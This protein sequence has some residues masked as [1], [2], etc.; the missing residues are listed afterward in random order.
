MTRKT[1]NKVIKVAIAGVGNCASSLVQ[2]LHYYS[3]YSKSDGLMH[4]NIGGYLPT[5]IEITAAFDIDERKVGKTLSEA[6]F[7][8]P[9]CTTT[10]YN[11]NKFAFNG[12]NVEVLMAPVM[13]GYSEHM[14]RFPPEK[15]FIVANKKSVDVKKVLIESG[16]DI[17]VN[18][19]PV[20]SEN[21]AR[22][23][24]QAC[25]EADVSFI[26]C[27][28]AFIV[29]DKEW[30]ERFKVSGIPA[31]GD[32]IKSQVG[33]T[34]LHRTIVQ[35]FEKR[36]VKVEKSYQL[37]VGGNTDFMNM[38]ERSRLASKKKS[39]TEAVRSVMRNELPDENLHIGPSDY[40]PWLKDKKICFMR[41][42]G[43]G[44]GGVPVNLEVRL[45]VEDSPNSA[46]VV[47]DVIRCVK[48]ARDRG[49]GGPLISVASY[50]M[51]H[52]PKQ[53][54]DDQAAELFEKFIRG[55]LNS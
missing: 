26:N 19:V 24:A 4:W 7:S 21:A 10:I 35:L 18:Y 51:K 49:V 22:F 16:A 12:S 34:I 27:M 47:I 25:I 2:G 53:Y 23:Y 52:P 50:T 29:S 1:N 8:P 5:D 46:A 32:D 43:K 17:L 13:D 42:E 31:V 41:V 6:I 3:E 55:E 37:N 36:G 15:T 9:N 14:S 48:L 44:F 40:V 11:G 33:A 28:P 45:E 39:K 20:G 54:P 38:L 30:G